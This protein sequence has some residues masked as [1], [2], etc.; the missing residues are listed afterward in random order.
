MCETQ[1]LAAATATPAKPGLNTNVKLILV[2]VVLLSVYSSLVSN[3]P[4]AAYINIIRDDNNA[5]VGIATGIQG[6]VNLL[7]ALP[8]GAL[9]DRIGRE[10]LLRAAAVMA[11]IA[12]AY[13]AMCLLY[14]HKSGRFSDDTTYY[15]LCGA[16]ALWGL[17]M[18]LHGGP[19]EALF[20][21]SVATG[22]RSKVYVW[23]SSLRTLGNAVGPLVSIFCFLPPHDKWQLSEL[24]VILLVGVGCAIPPAICLFFFRD[25]YSLGAASEGLVPRRRAAQQPSPQPQLQPQPPQQ[26]PHDSPHGSSSRELPQQPSP[27]PPRL[28]PL[29][30]VQAEA[31][32][33][34]EAS[35]GASAA[36]EQRYRLGCCSFSVA[37]VAPLVAA[38][39]TLAFLGS[40]SALPRYIT[41]TSPF[42]FLFLF[43]RE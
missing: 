13:T 21:D 17:F 32:Q 9:A 19:L 8:V 4:L 26:Q 20:G 14:L 12:A 5:S 2:Y 31:G 41:V 24:T 36:P 3:T 7:I 37:H 11:L 27:P 22:D 10:R 34:H 28:A 15:S 33:S 43:L 23:R 40:G 38:S 39:D 30:S 35:D 29:P 6:I 25:A 1:P 42:H 16:S 18:G